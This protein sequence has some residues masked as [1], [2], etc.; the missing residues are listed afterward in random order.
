LQVRS[1][2]QRIDGQWVFA[3]PK[4]QRSRRSITLS[5][6]ATHAL[7]VHRTRQLEEI[8]ALGPAWVSYDLVFCNAT[9]EPLHGTNFGKQHFYPLLKR[10]GLPR[11]RPH[12]LRHSTATILLEGN[13]HPK[14]VQDLLGHS[15][16]SMTLDTYSHVTQNMQQQVADHM[17]AIFLPG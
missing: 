12:D 14:Y 9:G 17:D 10:A 16:I 5:A 7:R 2:L 3:E 11:I 15:Q 1:T 4:T 13:V 8:L 6:V